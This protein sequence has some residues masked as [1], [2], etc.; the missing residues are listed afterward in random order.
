V[1]TQDSREV[2]RPLLTQWRHSSLSAGRRCPSHG[3][4]VAENGGASWPQFDTWPKWLSLFSGE[5]AREVG[6]VGVVGGGWMGAVIAAQYAALGVPVTLVESN[7]CNFSLLQEHVRILLAHL[8][9]ELGRTIGTPPLQITAD[10]ES[11]ADCNLVVEAITESLGRKRNL[12]KVLETVVPSDCTLI[13]GTSAI[14]IRLLSEG[15]TRPEQLVGVHFF[16]PLLP[17]TRGGYAEVI[18]GDGTRLQSRRLAVLHAACLGRIA[19]PVPD[20]PGFVANRL[21]FAYLQRSLRLMAWGVSA[22]ELEEATSFLGPWWQPLRRLDEIGL[23][24]AL[25]VGKYLLAERGWQSAGSSSDWDLLISWVGRGR[26]GRKSGEGFY[27]YPSSQ[28]GRRECGGFPQSCTPSL[29]PELELYDRRRKP[30]CQVQPVWVVAALLLPVIAESYSLWSRRVIPELAVIDALSVGGLLLP[31]ETG[32]FVSWLKAWDVQVVRETFSRVVELGWCTKE[33]IEAWE[34]L[35]GFL[36]V[37]HCEH[38][39]PR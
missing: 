18:W 14:P 39:F 31:P 4:F 29:H 11:L 9:R 12:F 3:Q 1:A 30:R 19:I 27:L 37:A 36:E 25:R 5:L 2:F 20:Q 22:R 13:T 8:S 15:L 17:I 16:H 38:P 6:R 34:H 23:D 28:M 21:L 32:G 10:L 24:T 7:A 33:E 26:L 35:R